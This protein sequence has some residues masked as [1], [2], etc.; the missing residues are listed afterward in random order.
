MEDCPDVGALALVVAFDLKKASLLRF[1][2]QKCAS[3]LG[4]FWCL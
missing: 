1:R 4:H 2:D 3:V